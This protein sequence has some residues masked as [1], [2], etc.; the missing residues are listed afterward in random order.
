[1]IAKEQNI[2]TSPMSIS[3]ALAMTSTGAIGN[4]LDELLKTMKV[5]QAKV[6]RFHTWFKKLKE[7]VF[8]EQEDYTLDVANRLYGE[9][10]MAFLDK[11]LQD[12]NQDGIGC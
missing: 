7:C 8:G 6:E 2:V 10:S 5:D 11:F 9:K 4:K 12:K 3:F 1:M